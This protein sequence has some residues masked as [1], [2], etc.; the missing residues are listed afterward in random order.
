[1]VNTS[2]IYTSYDLPLS[3]GAFNGVSHLVILEVLNS[4]DKSPNILDF[5]I[6]LGFPEL[7][8]R[9]IWLQSIIILAFVVLALKL[10]LI[11]RR[12]IE[13]H[14]FSVQN[15]CLPPRIMPNPFPWKLR[16]YFE[17]SNVNENLLDDYLF[18]KYQANGLTH[19][20]ATVITKQVKA[21][22]TIEPENFQAVLA[23]KFD[24]Y[25]RPKFRAGAAKPFLGPGILTH[26]GP[27]WAYARKLMKS[28]FTR[29][30]MNDNLSTNVSHVEKM[31]MALSKPDYNGWTEH[32]DLMVCWIIDWCILTN[33]VI[34]II[35]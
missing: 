6:V 33:E 10:I 23:T 24:D 11:V 7:N 13:F 27:L 20:L 34:D 14:N 35:H 18:R 8:L 19:G 28:Q 16:R 1:M 21:I 22:S 9:E 15:Y 29:Q 4:F 26:D 17:L 5:P 32:I 31:F 2:F 3:L 12:I 25:E 30:R